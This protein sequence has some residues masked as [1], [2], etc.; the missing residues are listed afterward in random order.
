MIEFGEQDSPAFDEVMDVL[1]RYPDFD[2]QQLNEDSVLSIKCDR[3]TAGQLAE[4]CFPSMISFED[5]LASAIFSL[6]GWFIGTAKRTW[7]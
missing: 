7:S 5:S 1:K 2:C 4:R 3:E 6:S